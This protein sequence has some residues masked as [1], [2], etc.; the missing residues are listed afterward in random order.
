[1]LWR[2]AA[3]RVAEEEQRPDDRRSADGLVAGTR[4]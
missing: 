1:L 3:A 2:P 4:E